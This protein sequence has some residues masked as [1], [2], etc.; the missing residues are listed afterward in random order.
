M[1]MYQCIEAS[2]AR[3]LEDRIMKAITLGYI[4]IG[5][6]NAK[7]TQ[8]NIK[9]DTATLRQSMWKGDAINKK[10]LKSFELLQEVVNNAVIPDRIDDPAELDRDIIEVIEEHLRGDA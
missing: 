10:A 8:H 6:V 2:S 4:P 3:E 1:K 5:G 9:G 7:I